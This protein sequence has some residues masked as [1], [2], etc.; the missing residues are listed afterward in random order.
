M[1]G[2]ADSVLRLLKSRIVKF[3]IGGVVCSAAAAGILFAFVST[4]GR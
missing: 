2:D 1:K 4:A 3:L